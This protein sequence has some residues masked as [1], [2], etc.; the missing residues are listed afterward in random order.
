MKNRNSLLFTALLLLLGLSYAEAQ[1]IAPTTPKSVVLQ[2]G[3]VASP[4]PAVGSY[5]W[6]VDSLLEN[7]D[8]TQVPTGIL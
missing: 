3:P 7:L 5:R 6:A 2:P 1:V 4:L 8:K